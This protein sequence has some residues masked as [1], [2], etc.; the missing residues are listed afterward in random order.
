MRHTRFQ[1]NERLVAQGERHAAKGDHG[2]KIEKDLAS[3]SLSARQA[4]SL[5]RIT[6]GRSVSVYS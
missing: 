4:R 3:A 2:P 6:F 5:T 1:L